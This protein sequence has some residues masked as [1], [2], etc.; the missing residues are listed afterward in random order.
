MPSPTQKAGLPVLLIISSSTRPS[1]KSSALAAWLQDL[2]NAQGAF[3]PD[4]VELAD[5]DLPLLN[6][7]HHPRMQ[8]YE[9]DYTKAWAQRVERAAAVVVVTPE[10][11]HSYPAGLKNALDYLSLEWAGKPLGYVTYGGVSAGTRALVALQP[12]VAALGLQPVQ[13]A[14]NVPFVAEVVKADGSVHA[15]ETMRKAATSMLAALATRVGERR[16]LTELADT[17]VGTPGASEARGQSAN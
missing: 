16:L 10:Y 15:N 3:E 6:E 13:V 1:R 8:R 5:L 11:N 4:I 17:K 12:V 14:V 9:F 7:P 2:A